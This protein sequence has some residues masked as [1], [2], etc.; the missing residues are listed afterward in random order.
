MRTYPLLGRATRV[1]HSGSS[2]SL[3]SALA[4]SLVAGLESTG[5]SIVAVLAKGGR[6][7]VVVWLSVV[8]IR[9][10]RDM[11]HD[12]PGVAQLARWVGVVSSSAALFALRV[13]VAHRLPVMAWSMATRDP[14]PVGYLVAV[15][16][17]LRT[18]GRVGLLLRILATTPVGTSPVCYLGVKRGRIALFGSFVAG[19]MLPVARLLLELPRCYRVLMER[20][21]RL[22]A[23]SSLLLLPLWVVLF[24]TRVVSCTGCDRKLLQTPG[25]RTVYRLYRSLLSVLR[26]P[27]LPVVWPFMAVAL[28]RP[29][30]RSVTGPTGARV[31]LTAVTERNRCS[32]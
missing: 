10:L 24:L 17:G 22:L 32:N 11:W 13:W 28:A 4:G 5:P 9:G 3:G 7:L 18:P 6:P 29:V 23:G 15:A 25:V 16:A 27:F 21:P 26:S 2:E 14:V 1:C 8:L 12:H 20:L 30:A 31:Q 19:L